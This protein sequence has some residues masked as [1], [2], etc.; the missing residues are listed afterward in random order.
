[1]RRH[2]IF[3]LATS[4]LY[5]VNLGVF[6]HSVHL[7]LIDASLATSL[8]WASALTYLTVFALVRSGFTQILPDPVL[9]LPHGLASIG[10]CIVAYTEL[11]EHR[12]NV[13]ILVAETLV[14]CM[15]R[16]RP[17][18]MLGLGLT[19]VAMLLGAVLWLIAK[20]PTHFPASTGLMHF[21]IGG[22]TLLM[23]SL[24]AKWVTD[25]RMRIGSQAHELSRALDTLQNMATQDTL[26]SLL[27]RR[28]M[29]DLAEA[30]I[31]LMNRNGT[32]LSVALIDLDHFKHIN[33]HA[34]HAAGDAVLCGFAVHAQ[35]V[36]RQVDKIARWGGEEFLVLLPQVSQDNAQS[37]I[38]R[39]RVSTECLAYAGHPGLRA[40][41]SAG[42][43]EVQP[44]ETLEQVIDRADRAL[45]EAK[46]R[47]RN[48]SERA[49]PSP[50]LGRPPVSA[51]ASI[52]AL[53]GTTP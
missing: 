4:Q 40:T 5:I 10:L 37:A 45:Y 38:E 13:L 34:G 51:D 21:V 53:E 27:N 14:M 43:A 30:E 33:D 23:L 20:D 31:M 41:F 48:R 3:V 8:S 39:L 18:Q 1:M 47:G 11:G 44:G 19:S 29:T 49:E 46:R 42:I 15:F 50:R 16:L 26:T 17:A 32:P 7:G 24:V 12:A 6:W 22:S 25:I 9:T 35:G 36:L 28:T 52:H 2:V